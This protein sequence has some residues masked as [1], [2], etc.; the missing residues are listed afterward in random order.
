MFGSAKILCSGIFSVKNKFTQIGI[1]AF[2]YVIQ[3]SGLFHSWNVSIGIII[4][5]IIDIEIK[6]LRRQLAKLKTVLNQKK[7]D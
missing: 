4:I 5:V 3:L 6:I 2:G 1:A 7:Q